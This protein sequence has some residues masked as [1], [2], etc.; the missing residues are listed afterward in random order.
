M[1]T[2]CAD[3]SRGAGISTAAYPRTVKDFLAVGTSAGAVLLLEVIIIAGPGHGGVMPSVKALPFRRVCASDDRPVSMMV[4]IFPGGGSKERQRDE[5]EGVNTGPDALAVS[6]WWVG[7]SSSRSG[8]IQN[9]VSPDV[10]GCS[11]YSRL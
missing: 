6:A 9:R 8:W 5:H 1:E 4:F 10:C 11:R 7:S 3:E 2:P